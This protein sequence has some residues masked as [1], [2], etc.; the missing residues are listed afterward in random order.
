MLIS[1]LARKLCQK[2]GIDPTVLCGTGPRGR[3]MAAD[4]VEPTTAPVS[5]G[6]TVVNDFAITPTRPEIDGYYVYD[7]EVD[8]A[9]LAR[10]S[11]PIAVQCEKLLEKRY[12]LFDYITRAVV[13]ACTSHPCWMPA[14]GKVDVLLFEEEGRKVMGIEN[15]ANKSIYRLA[16]ETSAPRPAPANFTPHI[17]VCDAHTTR[18]Q[19]AA[20]LADGHRPGFAMLARGSR[21]KDAIRAGGDG[22]YKNTLSYTFYAATTLPEQEA[23]RIAAALR[24]LLYNPVRLLLLS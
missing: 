23:N 3:I 13:K 2:K 7:Q 22:Q 19:V 24:A 15:A 5:R 9:A 18:E 16:R 21:E 10:I 11:L 12:S 1:P 4:V 8:M 17:I 20:V 6:R 14:D